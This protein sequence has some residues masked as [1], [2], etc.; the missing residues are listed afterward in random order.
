MWR[1]GRWKGLSVGG[2]ADR[3]FLFL[4]FLFCDIIIK[5]DRFYDFL[6]YLSNLNCQNVI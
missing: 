2:G 1:G 5:Y 6:V 3:V 4:F